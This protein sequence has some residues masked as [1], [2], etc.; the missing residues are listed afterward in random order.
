MDW[1]GGRLLER[2]QRIKGKAGT[3]AVFVRRIMCYVVDT[4]DGEQL[5]IDEE[6]MLKEWCEDFR[7]RCPVKGKD[8]LG[9]VADVL[10]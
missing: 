8:R 6:E 10:G 2:G 9:P 5:L 3:E 4:V 7:R 1:L